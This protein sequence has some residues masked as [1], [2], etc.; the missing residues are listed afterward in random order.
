MAVKFS[1]FNVGATVSDIDYIVGYKSTDNVKIPIGLVTAN[2][3]YTVATAQSGLNETLTLTGSDASTDVITFT[4]GANITLTDDG[5]GNG[6]TIQAKGNVDGTGTANSITK[7]ADADTITDSIMSETAAGGQFTDPYIT[8]VGAGG[9]VST[10]NLEINGFLLDSNGQKGTAGQILSSTGTLTDW[11]DAPSGE[12]YDLNSTTDGANVDVNLTST[13]GTDN[14]FV[15]LVPAGGITI[16]QVGN[17]VTLDTSSLDTRL[18]TAEADID[19]NTASITTEETA[20]I[21]ADTTLQ[22]NIDNEAATRLANDNTLQSNIDAEA[23]TRLAN[24]NTLQGNIDTEASTRSSADTALQGQIDSNDTDIATNASNIATNVTDIATN[25]TNIAS[26]DTD[27][28]NLQSSKQN[29][30]EKNQANGYAPLD[31]G[32]KIPIAN[33]PDSVVGQVEYQGTWNASTNTPTLPSA[34]TVKGHYYVVSV[35]GTYETIT[36]AIGDW[37]ISNG[38]AWEKIDNTDAVTTVFGRLGAIVANEG[39]YS[40]YYPLIADLTAAETDIATNAT[41]I[42]TNTSNISTNTSDIATNASDISSNDTDITDLQTD[43][44][45]KTGGTITGNATITGNL[46]VDTNTLYVD[47]STNNVGIGTDNPQ[48]ELDIASAAP[49][50]RLTDTDGGY[51]DVTNISGNLFLQ[52]DKGN[53]ESNSNMRFEIDGSEAMRIISSGNVGIGTD[54]PDHILCIEDTE[55]TFRIFDTANTL[56]QEQTI[57]FGTEPGNRTHAEISGINTNTG[58]AEGGLIFKT[59]SGASLTERMRIDSSGN[60]RIGG[61]G[62]PNGILDV[63]TAGQSGVPSLGT[64]GNGINLTRTD[65]QV[66]GSIGYTTEGHIYIQSQRFDSASSNNLF[67]QPVGGNVGIGT[68]SPNNK[69][70]VSGDGGGSAISYFNNTNAAGYGILINTYDTNN[71]RYALRVNTGAGT[72]F[73]VGNG[74]NVGIGVSSSGSKLHILST[75]QTTTFESSTTGLFN[76]YANSNGIFAYVGTGSQTVLGTGANDF[77]IQVTNNFVISTGG[78]NEKMRITSAGNVGIGTDSPSA[79]LEVT[80]ADSSSILKLTRTG[81]ASFS[82]LISDIGEGAAQLWFNADTDDTGFVF[83]PKD[84][85]G[86][87]SNAFFIAPSGSIGIGTTSPTDKLSVYTVTDYGNNSEY[88][89]ATIGLGNTAYPVSIRSYRYGGSYLNGLDFYY[90]NGTPQLGMRIDS[91]GNVGIGTSSPSSY[92][93]ASDNLVV[94]Q[95][96]GGGGITV[97]TDTSS[98]GALYFADGINGSEQYRGGISYN[99]S[100]DKLFLVSGGA[101]KVTIQGGGNVGI[102]TT[103]PAANLEVVDPVSGNFSGEIRI[104]GI[105]SSR[106]LLLRQDSATEYTIGASGENALLKFGT[107][108]GAVERMRIDSS[109]NTTFTSTSPELTIKSS[110][111]AVASGTSI[112]KLAWFTSDPTT[113]TGAGNVT[114]METKSTT[115]NGSD[116][117]FIINKREGSGGGSCYMNLGGNS[118][119]SISF[120]TNTS[121][122]GTERMRI[123]SGGDVSFKDTSANEAFYWDASSG[124]LGINV[125]NPVEHLDVGGVMRAFGYESRSGTNGITQYTG[126]FFNIFWTGS[127]AQLYIDTA[128][129]GTITLTSDYRVKKNIETQNASAIER[130][131]AL[132]PVKYEYADYENIFVADN[133]QREG[134]IAHEVA[135]IIPSAVEGEKDAENA[136][137]SLKL[138]AML[139]VAVKAIQEQQEIINDLKARIETLENQ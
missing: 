90:N 29:I 82:T 35:G 124:H 49:Q 63:R 46:I 47:S 129:V 31:S 1:Q 45:D 98:E 137:Q 5:V 108:T 111:G 32:A 55:P 48:V 139:S 130:I 43:K 96:S 3:T 87:P 123:K 7:W 11:V 112:G 72:V 119:G 21:A 126:D 134:F 30:S 26:N 78:Y 97:V 127:S 103:S 118:D 75:N 85:S 125:N 54:S 57:S 71:A 59:N 40:S 25:V 121:G 56:N 81:S 51:C 9:G 34:S 50:V 4:A 132:R 92:F 131:N 116:Y 22:T 14:S 83:R 79:K 114:T 109:G 138:D 68:D 12:T 84:S 2:T 101:S 74:G 17:V 19:T 36:Y 27:I 42:S 128:S 15:K 8:V 13:S 99:H 67:L 39:D 62:T 120:G 89:N 106:R 16:S 44:Y 77:G 88:A 38:V 100:L 133:I 61:S 37:I 66:G 86:N 76:T 105:G 60:I 53:T 69:L 18:T 102:G 64:A 70:T 41:N 93:S 73:N 95:A 58:N 117:A 104:G 113:P 20:R 80:V 122:A 65:G 52:A 28:S 33:L 110:N 94:K 135:Q 115:G 23:A 91:S 24:D 10:Q 107:G 136:F 6:F